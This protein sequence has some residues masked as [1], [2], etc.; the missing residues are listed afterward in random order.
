MI[1]K[2]NHRMVLLVFLLLAATLVKGQEYPW[3]LQYVNNMQ[4]I[5]PAYV[6]IW[7]RAG[8][9]VT[10]KTNWVGIN[11]A[12]VS[13]YLNCST[14]IREQKSAIGLSIQRINIGLEKQLFLTGDYSYRLRMSM[15]NYLQLGFRAGIVNYDNNLKDYQPYPDY[16]PDPNTVLDVT[17][18]NMSVFGIGAVYFSENYYLSLSMPEIISNTFNADQANVMSS[19][20]YKT[21]YLSGGYV[22]GSP[23]RVRFRPNLL[24][25]ATKGA[26]TYADVAAIVYLPPVFQFGVNIRSNG[27]VCFFSQFNVTDRIKVGYAFDYSVTSDI[28]KYQLGT[29]ELS[30]GYDFNI[31]KRKSTRKNYF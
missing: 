13:Q 8:V 26:P 28:R 27:Q 4:T 14:P 30:V 6:G 12:P 22:F 7:D 9:M 31:Y 1:R 5:N 16:I 10:T 18:H 3:S 19:S 20:T 24:V 17:M 21:I 15:N 11:G 23:G 2:F 25:A 29:H